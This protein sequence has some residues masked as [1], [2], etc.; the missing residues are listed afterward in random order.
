MEAAFVWDERYVTGLGVVDEEHQQLV[1]I[2]NEVA[3]LRA[4][5]NP[6]EEIDAVLDRLVAYAVTHFAH[7]EE[8]MARAGCDARHQDTHRGH[9]QDFAQQVVK[10]REM[11]GGAEDVDFLLRFLTS[12][13]AFHILGEDQFMARQIHSIRRGADPAL[14]YER[15]RTIADPATATLLEALH[16]LYGLVAGRNRALV[17]LNRQLERRV[18]ERT[19]ALSESNERLQR[20]RGELKAALETIESTQRKLMQSEKM[21]AVGQLAAGVAHEINNP[22][23]FVGSN[24]G[25]L[26]QYVDRLLAVLAAYERSAPPAELEAARRA[27]DLDYLRED[28]LDL[29]RESLDGIQRVRR[30]VADLKDFSHV[31]EAE[32]QEADLNAGLDSTLNVV[33]N[34]V[35][36][37]AEV[38]KE[39][40]TLPLVRCIAAQ[41]NQVFMNL[42]VNAAQAI[43][44]QGAISLRT[45]T[46]GDRVWVEVA[47]TGKGIPEEIRHRILEPFFTTK[48]VG[49]GTGL[50]LSLSYDIVKKHGGNLEFQSE[51]GKG[52]TFRVTLPVAGPETQNA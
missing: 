38:R 46:E 7:E 31:D 26:R 47:D 8:M 33:W 6:M 39:Y 21:A 19:H 36:Y 15:E 1:R 48:P 51:P 9:H 32:W 42:I 34:E 44:G 27:A 41:V 22:I 45:G 18:A 11:R 5:A 16:T 3:G 37:K 25:T 35:K 14:A 52:S 29:L 50:G 28:V 4:R 12:W 2:V 10:L 40:G 43:D 49:K 17:D 20:E 13:L 23:G 30:I 24:L